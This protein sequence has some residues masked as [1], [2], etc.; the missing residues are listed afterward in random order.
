[1]LVPVQAGDVG[2]A[3]V[4]V[5]VVAVAAAD[6]IVV[7]TMVVAVPDHLA[8]GADMVVDVMMVVIVMMAVTMIVTMIVVM[9]MVVPAFE[10]GL[11]SAAAADRTHQSTS[12][13]R[14][15]NSS[16]PVSTHLRVPQRGQGLSSPSTITSVSHGTQ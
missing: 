5:V 2:V 6:R 8:V 12:S 10:R 3:M 4:M 13:S 11:F 9:V 15:R 16:P 14:T 1:M 7:V